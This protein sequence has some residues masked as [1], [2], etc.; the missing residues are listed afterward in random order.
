MEYSYTFTSSDFSLT[1]GNQRPT[2]VSLRTVPVRVINKNK[3]IQAIFLLDD[4]TNISLISEEG[5]KQLE[6]WGKP[7]PISLKG[8]AGTHKVARGYYSKVRIVAGEVDAQIAVQI[9]P[10][11][12]DGIPVT[13]WNKYKHLWPHLRHIQFPRC[14]DN[15]RVMGILGTAQSVLMSAKEPDIVGGV[16]D[17]SAR[18]TPLGWTAVG[19][20]EP[21]TRFANES[22]YFLSLQQQHSFYFCELRSNIAR[23]ANSVQVV[24]GQ[25][26]AYGEDD[27]DKDVELVDYLC[28][29]EP[30]NE[31]EIGTAKL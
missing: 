8:V 28:E 16:N 15:S 26:K 4:G 2:K 9:I 22:F 1:F 5:A 13:D 17:P 25:V 10:N 31:V 19:L 3:E 12:T 27:I 24:E 14:T 18:H 6:L 29:M 30:E 21:L 20:T 23:L 11:A 7:V